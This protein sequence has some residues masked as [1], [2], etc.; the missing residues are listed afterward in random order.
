MRIMRTQ[1]GIE[2]RKLVKFSGGL[3]HPNPRLLRAGRDGHCT[4]SA[5]SSHRFNPHAMLLYYSNL[6]GMFQSTRPPRG[7]TRRRGCNSGSASCFNP[8]A[9][10]GA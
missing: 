1:S 2:A 5:S 8:H 4:I 10:R 9:P 3:P 7:V 6:D